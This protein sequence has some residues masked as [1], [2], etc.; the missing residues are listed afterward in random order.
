MNIIEVQRDFAVVL[1]A[2]GSV[3]VVGPIMS[4]DA[5]NKWVQVLLANS[6]LIEA[7]S[8]AE[9]IPRVVRKQ[10]ESQSLRLL[11]V[12]IS[13]TRA[14]KASLYLSLLSPSQKAIYCLYRSSK[15]PLL[16]LSI[17][18]FFQYISLERFRS[19]N[20]YLYKRQFSFQHIQHLPFR[21]LLL[22][23]YL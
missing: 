8:S 7:A 23:S 9:S 4:A 21:P 2:K 22:L 11:L 3:V 1:Y 16:P 19:S 14:S 15:S 5:V 17:L 6:T 10:S 13:K 20:I 12:V 18:N